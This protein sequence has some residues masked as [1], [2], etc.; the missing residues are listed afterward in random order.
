MRAGA[1]KNQFSVYLV[2][3]VVSQL[4][5]CIFVVD[6]RDERARGKASAGRAR[7]PAACGVQRLPR[8]VCA[9]EHRVFVSVLVE[10]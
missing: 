6:E 10:G 5:C 1:S 2:S 8:S 3:S 9:S 4:V 7:Q